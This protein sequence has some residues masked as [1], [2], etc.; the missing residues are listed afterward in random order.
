MLT[1]GV[2]YGR[3]IGRTGRA[4]DAGRRPYVAGLPFGEGALTSARR[5]A[6]VYLPSSG[7]R[8]A[9]T[10]KHLPPWF[11]PWESWR[12][13]SRDWEGAQRR[14]CAASAASALREFSCREPST[15]R[16]SRSAQ[17]DSFEEVPLV[18]RE[19]CFVGAAGKTT[20]YRIR[21]VTEAVIT[22]RS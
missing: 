3:I 15:A 1:P 17:D 9:P 4:A 11:S 18:T 12:G 8:Q 7:R 2:R 16:Q 13:S 21:R 14:S 22:G 19:A 20:A 6:G 5:R 10:G